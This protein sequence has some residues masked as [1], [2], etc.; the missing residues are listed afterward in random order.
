MI[1][2][3]TNSIPLDYRKT[4]AIYDLILVY[5]IGSDVYYLLFADNLL[6]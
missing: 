3:L 6:S 1:V 4:P 2:S 5:F